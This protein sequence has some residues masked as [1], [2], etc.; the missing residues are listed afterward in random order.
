[1]YLGGGTYFGTPPL[2]KGAG[3]S[4]LETWFKEVDGWPHGDAK[5]VNYRNYPSLGLK[6]KF[7]FGKMPRPKVEPV[8]LGYGTGLTEKDYVDTG[9]WVGVVGAQ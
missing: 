7:D 5:I 8:K 2:R 3:G 4:S 9:D 6:R 1:M